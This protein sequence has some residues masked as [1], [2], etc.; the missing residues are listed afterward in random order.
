MLIAVWCVFVLV[1]IEAC[2]GGLCALLDVKYLFDIFFNIAWIFGFGGRTHN[3][4]AAPI[5]CLSPSNCVQLDCFNQHKGFI[6]AMALMLR[7]DNHA[8]KVLVNWIMKLLVCN[9]PSSLV[10]S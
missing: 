3:L 2:F 7:F 10:S 5:F 9:L 4:A 6:F 8:I 1:M